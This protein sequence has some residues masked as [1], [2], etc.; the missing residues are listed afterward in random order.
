[1]NKCFLVFNAWLI[2]IIGSIFGTEQ[3]KCSIEKAPEWIKEIPFQAPISGEKNENIYYLLYDMQMDLDLETKYCHLV[4]TLR[5][6]KA[7]QQGSLIEIEFDPS[8]E[9]VVLHKLAIYR[10][11]KCIDKIHSSRKEIIQPERDINDYQFSGNKVWMVILD[12]VQP[13]DIIE[14]SYSKLG[15]NPIYKGIFNEEFYLQSYFPIKHGSYRIISSPERQLYFKNHLKDLHPK[16]NVLQNAQQE[17]AWEIFNVEPYQSDSSKPSWHVDI[18]ILQVSEFK[19]WSDIAQWG[20]EIF[21]L[22]ENHSPEMQDL[23]NQWQA[24]S[25]TKEAQIL[26]ALHY[27]Q[28][29][30]RYFGI[31]MGSG[32]HQPTDPNVIL[33]RRYGDC[34]DKT[35]LLKAFLDLMH[36]DSQPVFVSSWLKNHLDEW[37][38]SFNLFD[39]VILQVPHQGQLYW[40]DPTLS[41]QDCN[42]LAKN[43][44][45]HYGQGLVLDANSTGLSKIPHAPLSKTVVKTNIDLRSPGEASMVETHITYID[46]EAEAMKGIYQQLGFND[47]EKY[48]NDYFS[49]DLGTVEN[50]ISLE[51]E[52]DKAKN[53]F[54]FKIKYSS[55]NLWKEDLE[56]QQFQ[57][58]LSPRHILEA[59]NFDHASLRKAPISLEYPLHVEEHILVNKSGLEW[60]ETQIQ[61]QFDNNAIAFQY[62]R[63]SGGNQMRLRYEYLTKKDHV[64][65]D[66]LEDYRKDIKE[67]EDLIYLM[68]WIPM[69]DSES[70]LD[71]FGN[72]NYMLI[73]ILTII[74]AWII[75]MLVRRKKIKGE[76]S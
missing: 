19:S 25:P 71:L 24:D 7:V 10:N 28:K 48:F 70:I 66:D 36:I 39:H 15:R 52:E 9:S 32:T 72:D 50:G 76:K 23:I 27:V 37:H 63:V 4:K 17:W 6:P 16:Q 75:F 45:R 55:S 47:I 3:S 1:M 68:S 44:C 59:I 20:N 33:Q 8:Y 5:T 49:E 54:S 13:E 74:Y 26:R 43:I 46:E 58:T 18:P 61:K 67:M 60:P 21:K 41:N 11:G 29:E 12:D 2:L 38:P 31:E 62:E 57:Y 56:S 73:S 51:D 34:K 22:P 40:V 64:S 30:I 42:V 69:N 53:E 35:L 14:Y 65:A